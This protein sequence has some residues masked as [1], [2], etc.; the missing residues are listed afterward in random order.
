M[1]LKNRASQTMTIIHII[2]IPRNIEEFFIHWSSLC[3]RVLF[4]HVSCSWT[5]LLLLFFLVCLLQT[6]NGEKWSTSEIFFE[7]DPDRLPNLHQAAGKLEIRGRPHDEFVSSLDIITQSIW[8]FCQ[9]RQL[10][11]MPFWRNLTMNLKPVLETEVESSV[12]SC[13][14]QT[15]R[16]SQEQLRNGWLGLRHSLLTVHSFW[17][18]PHQFA[19]VCTE[20]IRCIRLELTTN[21]PGTWNGYKCHPYWLMTTTTEVSHRNSVCDVW[22]CSRSI[23]FSWNRT[24]SLRL[25]A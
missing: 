3:R 5:V 7:I 11:G 18:H 20:T 2:T 17:S 24:R 14:S 10:S 16:N 21:Q 6:N 4:L 19:A 8:G 13:S 22:I 15:Q 9:R 25:T 12:L 1:T 23:G